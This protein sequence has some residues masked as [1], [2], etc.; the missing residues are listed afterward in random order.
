MRPSLV[1]HALI[2]V[3]FIIGC[4]SATK[5]ANPPPPQPPPPP[6]PGTL[7]MTV[8]SGDQQSG[9]VGSALSQP[10]VINVTRQGIGAEQGQ[11]VTFKVT[12]GSGSL[13][14]DT[15]TT[16]ADGL[17]QTR[18]TLGTRAADTQ[19]VEVHAVDHVSGAQVPAL[20]LRATGAPAAPAA[21]K[22]AAGQDVHGDAG[23]PVDVNPSVQ[24]KDRYGNPTPGVAVR[25][26]VTSGNGS[27]TAGEARTDAD[28]M[29]TV[30]SWVIGTRGGDHTLTA[31]A[32]GNA[33]SGNPASFKYSFC[34]CW[35][36]SDPLPTAKAALATTVL[37]GKLFASGGFSGG[38]G[39]NC[40]I[41]SYDPAIRVWTFES[42][43]GWC[44]DHFA[45]ASARGQVFILGGAVLNGNANGVGTYDTT[46]NKVLMYDPPTGRADYRADMSTRRNSF[47]AVTVDGVIY[48]M[49]GTWM[50]WNSGEG[51][52]AS[53][54][55]YNTANNTWTSK[56]PMPTPRAL[57]GA[58]LVDG[59]IYV[60][61]G[62]NQ[63]TL[64]ATVVAYD[65]KTDTW[66]TKA[67]MPTPRAA[68]AIGVLNG[69][70]YVA[71]GTDGEQRDIGTVV[72]YNPKKNR[73][74]E[75]APMPTSRRELAGAV[76][77]GRFY[78]AGGLT[79]GS[80]FLSTVEVY[81]P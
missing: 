63:S 44:G 61:G 22:V 19:K 4:E 38:A 73:W 9:T 65:P 18:W 29:A 50:D 72:S 47:G 10:L 45:A 74:K 14:A 25:F 51:A 43:L 26:A 7:G 8:S 46:L 54:E 36:S 17:V 58:A 16:G 5:P 49:G 71:G 67:P 66:T 78:A 2:G 64:L 55:A 59:I 31:T 28:G 40:D 1:L 53:M 81:K 15:D 27:V 21:L 62:F 3:A 24:L 69:Q 12:A 39:K 37:N 52:V 35:S 77:N 60:I 57:F 6:A 13:S 32:E 42:F 41:H 56:A 76:L 80:Q 30:G 23:D 68:F 20:T 48:A 34:D 75:R 79:Q 11:V 33:I 70:I